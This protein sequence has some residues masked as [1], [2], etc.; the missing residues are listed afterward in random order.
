MRRTFWIGATM[1]LGALALGRIGAAD[2]VQFS[3]SP[4]E[5]VVH[6]TKVGIYVATNVDSPLLV[7]VTASGGGVASETTAAEINAHV[8][9]IDGSVA[10]QTTLAALDEEIEAAL[11][12]LKGAVATETTLALLDEAIGAY[13]NDL[14]NHASTETTLAS[15]GTYVATET[16]LA[17]LDGRVAS[18]N[19]FAATETTLASI[20]TYVATETTLASIGTY[21]ATE[22]TLASIE[23]KLEDKIA[24]ETT[25]LAILAE[26]VVLEDK[27]AKETTLATLS[28][29]ATSIESKLEDKIAK[30]TTLQTVSDNIALI[31]S[32]I[33]DKVAKET[34]L[35]AV[36]DNVALIVSKL[37]DKVSKE[38]T[39][40]AILSHVSPKTGLVLVDDGQVKATAGT[41]YAVLV[42]GIG[43]TAGDK[44]EIKNSADNSGPALLTIV[45]DAVN[46]T[47]AFYPSVGITYGT[48]IY[49]DGTITGGVFTVTVVYE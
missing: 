44:I 30:E 49:S 27:L 2:T 26:L 1:I 24:K 28:T 14:K 22:T 34:T 3:S 23:L 37:E 21:V 5:K 43:V 31:T 9:S 4:G 46:G 38:T 19:T 12:D 36:S 7:N 11:L 47:W 41:V 20:G 18:L 10:T 15:I 33:E 16:T 29:T 35:Q 39:A 40:L 32:K 8:H 17:I 42:S 48:G 6:E 25:A 13:I 45:A